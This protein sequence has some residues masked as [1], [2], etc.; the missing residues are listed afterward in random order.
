MAGIFDWMLQGTANPLYSS[1]PT[2][3]TA[4]S[5]TPD[6]YNDY[7]KDIAGNGMELAA[8]AQTQPVP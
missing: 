1:G 5:S 3:T 6:W 7:I 2:T 4:S 8:R